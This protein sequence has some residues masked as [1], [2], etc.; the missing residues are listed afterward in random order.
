MYKLST[1]TI[2]AVIAK[3]AH[4]L[5]NYC[6]EHDIHYTVTGVSGG[7]D[8][9]VTLGLAAEAEKLAREHDYQLHNVGLLLPCHTDPDHFARGA[10]CVEKFGAQKME[11]D[12][13]E[14]YD[15]IFDSKLSDIQNQV[16][17]VLRNTGGTASA[18]F[19]QTVAQGNIR[20]RLRMMLGTY[21][22][23][24]LLRGL[25]LSTDNYSEFLMGFWTIC[26]DVGDFGMIQKIFKGLELYDIAQELGVPKSILEAMPDDGLGVLEGGDEAQLGADYETVDRVMIALMQAGLD[27]DKPDNPPLPEV[28]GVD[29]AVV[30][31][32]WERS[33][34][35]AFKRKG[36]VILERKDLGLPEV[37]DM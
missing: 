20:C 19:D 14:I 7:L 21:H 5:F 8:S 22:T 27:P 28:E 17:E 11:I 26:G 32:L 33:R 37:S 36:T 12:L 24:R 4:A 2:Q 13:T 23:A 9:A 6:R 34:K 16:D 25:V 3:A 10:E 1:D 18:E 15:F 35:N 29:S 31:K 30:A